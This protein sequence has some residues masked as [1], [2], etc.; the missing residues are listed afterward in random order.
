MFDFIKKPIIHERYLL[1]VVMP[2][3]ENAVMCVVCARSEKSKFALNVSNRN[4]NNSR[5]Y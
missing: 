3:P 4:N 2:T 5:F 1:C